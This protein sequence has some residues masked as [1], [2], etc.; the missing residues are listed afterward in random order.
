MM[1]KSNTK[2]GSIIKKTPSKKS[3]TTPNGIRKN[4]VT[5]VQKNKS[6]PKKLLLETPISEQH[7]EGSNP[8]N[9]VSPSLTSA[10]NK[11][12]D[13]VSK[14]KNPLAIKKPMILRAPKK[15]G[16]TEN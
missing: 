4:M 1:D 2:P 12:G 11:S 15:T 7:K 8:P 13:T 14:R 10:S 6:Q 3:R 16:Q 5:A 9:D